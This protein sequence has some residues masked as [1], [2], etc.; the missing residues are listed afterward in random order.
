MY[1]YMWTN[2]KGNTSLGREFTI[3][4]TYVHEIKQELNTYR[5]IWHFK[6]PREVLCNV[7]LHLGTI[8]ACAIDVLPLDHAVVCNSI[9]CSV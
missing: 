1:M 9:L 6:F 8:H 7:V 3:T 4:I 2:R 5:C